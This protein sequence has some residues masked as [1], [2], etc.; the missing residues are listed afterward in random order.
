MKKIFL[1]IL[2]LFL[3]V[4]NHCSPEKNIVIIVSANAEWNSVKNIVKA[5][6]DILKQ[7]PY[8]EF[9]FADNSDSSF[10]ENVI[11]FHGGWGKIDSAASTQWAIS[12]LNPKLIINI[13]TAGGFDKKVRMF[14]VILAKNA[15]V[16]DIIERMYDSQSAIHHYKTEMKLDPSIRLPKNLIHANIISADQDL[17]PSQIDTLSN[18][19]DASAADWE[20][21]SIARVCSKND[22]QVIILRGISDIVSSK[23]S[24]TYNNKKAFEKNT[25]IVMQKLISVIKNSF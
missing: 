11:F 22:I 19:Y 4:F 8:G 13:G 15:F 18:L 5:N 7:S 14:D 1:S 6:S 23:G 25:D 12:N 16:Y 9:F 3:F 20:S 17:D 21:A 24:I 2:F 10:K